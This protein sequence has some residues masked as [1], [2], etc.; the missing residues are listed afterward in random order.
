MGKDRVFRVHH[1]RHLDARTFVLRFDRNGLPFEP[2][3]YLSLGIPGSI[4]RRDYTVYSGAG[5][6]YLEVLVREIQGG[7]VSRA[8]KRCERGDPLTV[9]GP[10]GLFT[11]DPGQRSSARYL[12]IA[13]GTGISPFHCLVRSFADLDYRILHGVRTADE[14][15]EDASFEASRYVLCVSR[16]GGGDF[17]GRVTAY[18]PRHPADPHQFCYLCGNS[19]MIDECFSILREQGVPRE[20]LY[21]E[22]YF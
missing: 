11:T 1:V 20:H 17:R 8:L 12:F 15:Q 3:Q 18:L 13:S 21:A 7:L 4:A 6:D 2:G 19:D 5:E 14:H 22:V 9:E 10:H 16:G